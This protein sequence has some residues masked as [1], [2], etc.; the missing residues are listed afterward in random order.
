MGLKERELKPLVDAW[1]N[2]NQNIT[3]FWWVV[4][5]ATKDA[6]IQKVSSKCYGLEFTFEH[7]ILFI[8][9]PSGRR[10]AY[11]KAKIG[12]SQFGENCVTYMGVG[13]NKKCPILI[14]SV[15]TL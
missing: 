2:A 3:S 1:R 8:K 7:G 4:D 14:S 6:V 10:L 9:L 5:R 11:C 15:A 13:S 12:K